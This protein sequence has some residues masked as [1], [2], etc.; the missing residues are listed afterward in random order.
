[1]TKP[2]KTAYKEEINKISFRDTLSDIMGLNVKRKLQLLFVLFLFILLATIIVI[3]ADIQTPYEHGYLRFLVIPGLIVTVMI[4]M[5]T[6][7]LLGRNF[8]I[9]KR[10][11]ESTTELKKQE[12]FL[13]QTNEIADVGGWE[14]NFLTDKLMWSEQAFRIHELPLDYPLT[15]EA[16]FQF[17]TVEARQTLDLAIKDAIERGKSMDIEYD[18]VTAKGNRRHLRST[19]KVNFEK[20]KLV[21][22]YG[23]IQNIT[24]YHA[25]QNERTELISQLQQAQKMEAMGQL[26]GGVSHEFNNIL[27]SIIGYTDLAV[28]E[29]AMDAHS[30]LDF[31]L[32]QV[33]QAAQSAKNL[34]AQ[35]LSFSRTSFSEPVLL[36]VASVVEA[37]L[38]MLRPVMPS[39]ISI[40]FSVEKNLPKIRCDKT[41]LHQIVVNLCINA[42]DAM[43]GRGQLEVN[44]RRVNK[45]QQLCS[46]CHQ[47]F[48]GNYVEL[49]VSDNGIGVSEKIQARIFEPFFTTKAV[50]AGTGMGLAV[51]HG[52]THEHHGHIEFISQPDH[53]AVFRILF[54]QVDQNQDDRAMSSVAEKN[55]R[56]KTSGHILVVD[57]EPLLTKLFERA[58]KIRGH[59]VVVF[60]DPQEALA[61]YRENAS[62]IDLVVS[63][64][65]MPALTGLELASA[66]IGINP[67]QRIILC[68]AYSQDIDEKTWRALGI[69]MLLK[70][71]IGMEKL[72]DAVG[73]L[74]GD[75]SE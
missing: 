64:E 10:L 49:S 66:I 55:N 67:E 43:K 61:Y 65:I 21:R 27:Q 74:L 75:T 4:A 73:N 36:D 7:I 59:T 29:H 35:V 9:E 40:R 56:G 20:G 11:L 44:L 54:P 70:K 34:V 37:A 31:Y 15:R 68:T 57:D 58:L 41:Q 16:G 24:S 17:C 63:D 6:F 3:Y 23:S 25:L 53:G 48:S 69:K 46:S 13:A 2:N 8:L 42:R 28:N 30:N 62:Q 52:I 5:T 22:I 33:M 45:A 26:A 47:N 1:M 19:G 51:V 72:W 39:A 32:A 14:Y 50:G 38:D 12:E 60:N 71:P 18:I